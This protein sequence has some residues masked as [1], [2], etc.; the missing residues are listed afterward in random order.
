MKHPYGWIVGPICKP[1]HVLVA[2]A[3]LTIALLANVFGHT[4]QLSV[5]RKLVFE[6]SGYDPR[7]LLTGHYVEL[8][9]PINEASVPRDAVQ[10]PLPTYEAD[11]WVIL[12]QTGENG[13][14]QI[15][16]VQAERPAD[17]G[18]GQTGDAL[19]VQAK[20]SAYEDQQ[21]QIDSVTGDSVQMP[22]GA[23]VS[24]TL[25]FGIERY[26]TEQTNAEALEDILRNQN[27]PEAEA[28]PNRIQAIVV[29]GADRRARLQGLIVDGQTRAFSWF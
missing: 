4:N 2:G 18:G 26:F 28:N 10:L 9:L 17:T 24:V 8:R 11:A 1:W 5:G 21:W 16:R 20:A 12:R 3:V 14:W 23:S 27:G 6:A 19:W 29:I 25:R 22:P 15:T 13:A 7:A